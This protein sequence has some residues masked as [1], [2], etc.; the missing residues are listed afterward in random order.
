MIM[1]I[2]YPHRILRGYFVIEREH[3]GIQIS[4]INEVARERKSDHSAFLG[5]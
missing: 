2:P 1:G 3:S 4:S 5:G